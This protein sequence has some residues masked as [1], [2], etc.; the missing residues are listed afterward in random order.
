MKELIWVPEEL[1]K[2]YNAISDPNSAEAL[3]MHHA[4]MLRRDMETSVESLSDDIL[5]VKARGLEYRIALSEA[6]EAE[7][8]A[9]IKVFNESK[10]RVAKV[11]EE[12]DKHKEIIKPIMDDIKE[13]Q[14]LIH[15][16]NLWRLEKFVEIAERLQGVDF[17]ALRKFL[18][19]Q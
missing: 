12:V 3:L 11:K 16:E 18:N 1:A 17:V 13:L 19:G 2:K 6:W 5:R 9:I 10:D 14:S 15:N 8:E 4:E 7:Y